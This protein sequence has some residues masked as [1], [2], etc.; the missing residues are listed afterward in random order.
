MSSDAATGSGGPGRRWRSPALHL[1]LGALVPVWAAPGTVAGQESVTRLATACAGASEALSSPCLETVLALQAAQ[2]I[3]GLAA[4][5]GAELSGSSSTLGK[6][7]GGT[8]R[9]GL[10]GRVGFVDASMPGVL[11]P[12]T[13]P[14]PDAG[15]FA[16]SIQATAAVGLF[17]GFSPAPTVGGLLSLDVLATFSWVDLPGDRGFRDSPAGLGLGVRVG[18]FRESFTLPGITLSATRRW[19]GKVR[20]G[21]DGEEGTRGDLDLTVTSFRA[22]A[23][24]ELL[25]F[26]FLGGVGWDRYRSATTLVVLPGGAG[27]PEGAAEEGAFTSD[28]LLFFA[29]AGYTFLVAQISA[30]LGWARGWD[31]VPGR[32]PGG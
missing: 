23:G 29:G 6:R 25:A 28:R 30:E 11:G 3:V 16:P 19:M 7:Y 31:E 4:S 8:P 14:A 13:G 17:Q 1:A 27:G 12:A 26:G 22:S 20:L 10:A 18:V 21:G 2:G 32:S 15:A 24:K 9:F 5:G